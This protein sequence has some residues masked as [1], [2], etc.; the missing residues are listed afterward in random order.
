MF[1]V[2][3]VSVLID[4]MAFVVV[5]TVRW[6]VVLVVGVVCTVAGDDIVFVVDDSRA[7]NPLPDPD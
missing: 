5:G 2:S 1:D 4:I 7:L 6:I 3:A